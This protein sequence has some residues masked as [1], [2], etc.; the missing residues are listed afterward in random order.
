MAD[1]NS[2]MQVFLT[3]FSLSLINPNHPPFFQ[4]TTS[5]TLINSLSLTL[6]QRVAHFLFCSLSAPPCYLFPTPTSILAYQILHLLPKW[7]NS[8]VC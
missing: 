6:L 3:I 2:E 1:H 4:V 8:P 5:C 7:C